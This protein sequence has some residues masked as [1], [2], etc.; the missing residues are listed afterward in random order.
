MEEGLDEILGVLPFLIP[1][2]IVEIAL[3]VI[4][5]VD[6]IRR[7]RVRGDNKVVWA[8]I[9]VLINVIGPIAYLLAGRLE[10]PDGGDQD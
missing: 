9:I 10:G 5:L 6:L 1:L 7:E 2:L 8:L 3:L 4:A